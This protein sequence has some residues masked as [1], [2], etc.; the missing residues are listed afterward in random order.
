VIVDAREPA[1]GAE[2]EAKAVTALCFAEWRHMKDL[3][4]GHRLSRHQRAIIGMGEQIVVALAKCVAYLAQH[5]PH[6]AIAIMAEPEADR[7]EHIAEHA[8][9]RVENDLAIGDNALGG[10]QPPQPRFQRR[11]I[12]FAVVAIEEADQCAAIVRK[13]EPWQIADLC[14]GQRQAKRAI[15][16]SIADRAMAAMHDF[17]MNQ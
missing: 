16:E 1:V 6:L 3:A 15:R 2:V 10:E 9:E 5:R 11:T 7:I 17:A 13:A 14:Q 12:A 8:R 4:A